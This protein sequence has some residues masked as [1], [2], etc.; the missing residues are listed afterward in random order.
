ML[1]RWG[2]WICW[3]LIRRLSRWLVRRWTGRL[4]RRRSRWLVR[5][6]TGRSVGRRSRWLVRR[7]SGWFIRRWTGRLI[8]RRS[9][10][11]VRRSAGRSV[12]RRSWVSWRSCSRV[13]VRP[14]CG[15]GRLI[16]GLSWRRR[17]CSHPSSRSKTRWCSL[18]IWLRPFEIFL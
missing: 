10:S 5:C 7:L 6:W 9:R 12:G 17:C 11:L 3:R 13:D 2:T 14:V 18:I 4:I 1:I 15:R 16:N 8:R